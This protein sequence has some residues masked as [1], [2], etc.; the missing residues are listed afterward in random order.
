MP[1]QTSPTPPTPPTPPISLAALLAREEL[2]LRQVAGPTNTATGADTD[3][4]AVVHADTVIHWVHTSE[5]ADPYPY[6]LGGE[7]L[8]TAG[9]LLSDADHYVSR[10][11]AAGAAALGFG[12]APVYDTVPDALV[13]ACGRYGLPLIEVPP[14]TPFTAV[15]RAVWLLM[16]QARHHELRRVSQ[17]QQ[18]LATAAARPDPVPAVLHQ[19]ATRLGGAGGWTVLLGPGG[20]EIASAGGVPAPETRATLNRLAHVV[21]PSLRDA[22]GGG[23]AGTHSGGASAA[24][25]AP[26]QRPAPASATDS[27]GDTHLAAY[28]L[29]GGQDLVLGVAAD[30][31]EGGD[32]TIAGVAAVLLSLLT[33][34]HQGSAEAGRTTAL[35]RLLLGADA[36]AV[37]PLLGAGD[38]TV[39]HA[40]PAAPGSPDPLSAAALA[41][42]L[43]SALLAPDANGAVQILLT[44][45]RDIAPQPGWTLGVGPPVPPHDL[46]AS[47]TRAAQASHRAEAT[48]RDLVRDRGEAGAGVTSLVAPDEARAHARVQLA[49]I[50]ASPA[51]TGTLRTWLSLHGSWDRTAVALNVH[52]NTVRQRI[53]RCAALLGADLDDADVRMDL[54]FALRWL[55]E[56]GKV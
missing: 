4:D 1:D 52:R 40:R 30:R 41:A 35:V 18:G 19:L 12:V 25:G 9:V 26:P 37:A 34:P 33:T 28:A 7:L 5:M 20:A 10:V 45:D 8:L 2:G 32:H 27:V 31:R 16:A 48:R 36:T 3:A 24:E 23:G 54:W 6:L 50:S 53:A 44:G 15:A 11:V 29:A 38:W 21:N 43:G 42:D 14:Q 39:V 22:V 46:P 17:A 49:P 55:E 51:L 13:E 56:P 47:A